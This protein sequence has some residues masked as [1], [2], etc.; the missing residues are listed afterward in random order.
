MATTNKRPPMATET[1]DTSLEWLVKII[2]VLCVEDKEPCYYFHRTRSR[3]TWQLHGDDLQRKVELCKKIDETPALE[4]LAG[5]LK[6]LGIKPVANPTLVKEY[7][8]INYTSIFV[9]EVTKEIK[10]RLRV[11]GQGKRYGCFMSKKEIEDLLAQE[12]VNSSTVNGFW[13]ADIDN[14]ATYWRKKK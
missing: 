3:D 2:F 6:L 4:W 8:S 14:L 5:R 1:N 11:D 13:C 7:T 9:I 12:R 10:E